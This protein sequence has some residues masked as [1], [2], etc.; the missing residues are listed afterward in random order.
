MVRKNWY[1]KNC[2]HF[3]DCMSEINNAQV[4]NA[5]NI[6]AVML[7]YSL[8]QYSDNYSKLPQ[9]LWCLNGDSVIV[10]FN[11]ANI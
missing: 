9:S 2:A 4:F 8:I 7:M 5:K 11:V 1:F 10:D 6:D 3:T